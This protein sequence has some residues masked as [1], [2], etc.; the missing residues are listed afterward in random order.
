MFRAERDIRLLET[1]S[2]QQSGRNSVRC[3]SASFV[4]E[5]G[6]TVFAKRRSVFP[7]GQPPSCPH[8]K[9]DM[10]ITSGPSGRTQSC[11]VDNAGKHIFDET[12]LEEKR[13]VD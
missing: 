12:L 2:V 6:V 10:E 11:P 13:Y 1:S 9:S 5:G 3:R 7:T 8:D 4:G